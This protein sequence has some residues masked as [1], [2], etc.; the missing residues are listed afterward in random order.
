MPISQNL[1]FSGSPPADLEYPTPPGA[2]IARQLRTAIKDR[3][4][5]T[6]EIENWRGSGWFFGCQKAGSDLEISLVGFDKT[7]WMLQIA[8]RAIPGLISRLLGRSPSASPEECFA[9]ANIVHDT[10]AHTSAYADPLWEW[11]GPP[12]SVSGPRPLP[13][14]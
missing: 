2:S 6:T 9:L 7:T 12:T 4:W 3:G 8:P 11:D 10:L 13:P 1:L 5:T 14:P